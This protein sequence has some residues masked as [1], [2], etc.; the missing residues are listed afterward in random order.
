MIFFKLTCRIVN[1]SSHCRLD[2]YDTKLLRYTVTIDT[3]EV[4]ERFAPLINQTSNTA[5]I[6]T[7]IRYNI[8]RR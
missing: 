1:S 3:A 2:W 8:L 5:L 6:K 4:A 7:K